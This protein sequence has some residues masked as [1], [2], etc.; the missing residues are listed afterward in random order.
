MVSLDVECSTSLR[1]AFD[2]LHSCDDTVDDGLAQLV[3]RL[4]TDGRTVACGV[5]PAAQALADADVALGRR[6]PASTWH[7]DL[8]VD[9]LDGVWRIVHALPAARRASERGVEIATGASLLGALLMFPAS[10]AAGPGRSPP[11][12]GRAPGPDSGSP[13]MCWAPRCRR[14]DAQREWHALSVEQVSRLLPPPQAQRPGP[15]EITADS[16]RPRRTSA[17]RSAVEPLHRNVR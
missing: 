12:Q 15:T 2:D 16:D 13:A 6:R 1:S 11:A 7:A 14:V 17:T 4:Q 5:G 8:L 3:N 9:D 10:V